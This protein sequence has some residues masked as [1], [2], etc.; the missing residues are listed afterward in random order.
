MYPKLSNNGFKGRLYLISISIPFAGLFP[1]N[2]EIDLYYFPL[3]EN[4]FPLTENQFPLT[5]N[6]FPLTEIQFTLT[7][8]AISSY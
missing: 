8:I 2:E 3:T 7:K 5:E 1:P 6:Q 4:Q